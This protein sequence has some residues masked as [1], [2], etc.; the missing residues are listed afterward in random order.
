MKTM[1]RSGC[2]ENPGNLSWKAPAVLEEGCQ[3]RR[4]VE[5]ARFILESVPQNAANP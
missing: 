4:T 1:I 5:N 3:R 2:T